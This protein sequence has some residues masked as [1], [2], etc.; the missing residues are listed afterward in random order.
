VSEINHADIQIL[1]MTPLNPPEPSILLE[2]TASL[3]A[4]KIRFE[5]NRIKLPIGLEK[6][7]GIIHHPGAALAVPITSDGQIVLLRQYRFA[8]SRRILEFPAGT[9]EENENPL[10]SI[11]RELGEEAGYQ[12]DTWDPLGIMTPCPGYSNE[13]IHMFLARDLVEL[14]EKPSGDDDEDIEILHMTKSELDQC[15]SSGNELLDGKSLTAWYRAQQLL[16]I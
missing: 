16:K 12:A 8:I 5:L 2:T 3:E 7:F 11:Q 14:K 1:V 15:I 4:K 13:L 6:T 10:S 9:L